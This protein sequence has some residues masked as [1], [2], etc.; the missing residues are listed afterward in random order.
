MLFLLKKL[1]INVFNNFIYTCHF[2]H[3]GGLLQVL[4]YF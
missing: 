3:S 4:I 2:R 1:L